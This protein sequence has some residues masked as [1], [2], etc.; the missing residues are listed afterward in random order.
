M[1]QVGHARA[2]IFLRHGDAQKAKLAH[3]LPQLGR[4]QVLAVDFL[5]HRADAVL[6]PTMHH[7]AHRV[8]VFAEV[9]LHG[10]HEHRWGSP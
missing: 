5:G 10:G 2:A 7:L 1:G 8:D 4:K 6:R 3:L 9:E